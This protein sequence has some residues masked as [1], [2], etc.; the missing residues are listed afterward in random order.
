MKLL[1]VED[2]EFKLEELRR[3][4]EKL[5]IE[6][7]SVSDYNSARMSLIKFENEIFGVITDLGFP[8]FQNSLEYNK[9]N[10]VILIAD[11]NLQYPGMPVLINSETKITDD[12]KKNIEY[13]DQIEPYM[14]N[15]SVIE[16]FIEQ[17][18]I[19]YKSINN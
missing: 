12:M 14:Y 4:L 18:K 16:A 10:G 1:I 15:S 5:Q 11:I 6:Y 13:F 8:D 2:S 19:Y 7:F 17:C 3:D 9:Y